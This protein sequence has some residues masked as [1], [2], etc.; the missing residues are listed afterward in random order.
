MKSEENKPARPSAR[1]VRISERRDRNMFTKP[2]SPKQAAANKANATLSTGPRTA[3]GKAASAHNATSHGLCSASVSVHYWESQ[4][5]FDRM[6]SEYVDLFKPANRPE[7]DLVDRLVDSTWRRNRGVSM[8]TTLLNLEIEE[9]GEEVK[10]KYEEVG[11]GLLRVSL[12]FL[13]RHGEGVWDSLTRHIT[14]AERGYQRA[15]HELR[16]LRAEDSIAQAEETAA[17]TPETPET[18]EK[19]E[20]TNRTHPRTPNPAPADI[21]LPRTPEINT[22]NRKETPSHGK[23]D[24]A[25]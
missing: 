6:R 18:A 15:M 3:Q 21:Q 19:S 7:L 25:A 22:N 1:A 20:I 12:A 14:A 24:K 2:T 4:A 17:G 8:E 16:K 23:Q 10:Q 11:D 9:M 13:N 5:E